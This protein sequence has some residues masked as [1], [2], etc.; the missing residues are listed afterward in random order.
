MRL[1][2]YMYKTHSD[3]SVY[4]RFANPG[5]VDV[6]LL[7]VFPDIVHPDLPLPPSA[8]LSLHASI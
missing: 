3:L 2:S 7:K 4:G 1:G 5:Q 6:F 8:S